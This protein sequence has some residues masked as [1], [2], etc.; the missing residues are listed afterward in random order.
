[1]SFT[2]RLKFWKHDS[3]PDFPQPL[4]EDQEPIGMGVN[5]GTAGMPQENQSF[6]PDVFKQPFSPA[7]FSQSA[8]S[9]PF[10]SSAQPFQSSSTPGS[11]TDQQVQL[12][13]A[14]LDTIKAQLETVLQRLDAMSR[15]EER[16]ESRPYQ[17]RWRNV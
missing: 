14:K 2:D 10:S 8:A 3:A 9:S 6:N 16:S 5:A 1:M 15:K 12:I 17:D 13:S 7:S 4:P 11:S